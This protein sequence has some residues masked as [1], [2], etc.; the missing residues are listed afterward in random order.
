MNLQVFQ[1]N[2]TGLKFW[3]LSEIYTCLVVI[4]AANLNFPSYSSVTFECKSK[5]LHFPSFCLV[6]YVWTTPTSPVCYSLRG[7]LIPQLWFL[8][9][10]RGWAPAAVRFSHQ[11]PPQHELLVLVHEG[12][13]SQD[14]PDVVG[15]EALSTLGAADVDSW[16]W[17]LDAQILSQAVC[18]GAVVAGHDVWEV[19][20]CVAQ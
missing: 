8:P 3:K 4:S 5:S 19:I 18:A 2:I 7:H 17:D 16:L 9:A 14:H 13:V 1:D 6:Y 15:V 11:P 12:S 20:A 10:V